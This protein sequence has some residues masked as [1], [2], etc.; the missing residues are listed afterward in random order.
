MWTTKRSLTGHGEEKETASIRKLVMLTCGEIVKNAPSSSR[1]ILLE[2]EHVKAHRTKKDEKEMSHFEKFVSDGSGRADE[3]A[4]AGA[5]LDEGFMAETRAK[6]VQ[7]EREEVYAALQY[8]ASFHGEGAG[9]AGQAG[10]RRGAEGR[11]GCCRGTGTTRSRV[12]MAPFF[13]LWK[14]RWSRRL[15]LSCSS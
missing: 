7:Q 2:V 12:E 13:G 3:L 6:T 11:A 14:K 5:M 15:L 1:E 9:R 10:G 8:A 4:K